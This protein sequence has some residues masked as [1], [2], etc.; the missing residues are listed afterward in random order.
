M[1]DLE[2]SSSIVEERKRNLLKNLKKNNLWISIVILVAILIFGFYIR[3]LNVPLLKDA[4]T[5]GYITADL[6]PF[7]FLRYSRTILETGSLPSVDYM[8]YVPIGYSSI[9]EFSFLSYSIVYLF[10]FLS[11]FNPNMTIELAAN[12]YPPIA[13]VIGLI[14]FFLLVRKLFNDKIALI[15]T[16]FLAVIPTFLYR[17]MAGVADKEPMATIFFFMTFYFY[18][19]GYKSDKPWKHI[20]FGALA[21]VATGILSRVWGGVNFVYMILGLFVIVSLLFFKF[22]KKDF[23]LYSS[24]FIVMLPI[25]ILGKFSLTALLVSFTSGIAFVAFFMGLVYYTVF[26]AK[27][28]KIKETITEK[29][30]KGFLITIISLVLLILFASVFVDP[31]FIIDKPHAL[32]HELVNPLEDRWSKTVAESH[33]SYFSD[34][35]GNYGN[36]VTLFFMAG[37]ILLFWNLVK[38]LKSKIY[39]TVAYTVFIVLFGIHKYSMDAASLNGHSNLA[40]FLLVGSTLIFL[41][42]L[43]YGY[44]RLF[45]SNK[46]EFGKI[47]ESS[48]SYVFVLIWFIITLLAALRAVRL[49][50]IFSPIV[51]ILVAYLLYEGIL[52]ANEKIKNK[53]YK[54]LAIGLILILMINPFIT[55]AKDD[56]SIAKV[57]GPIY[58]GQW[59]Y[60]M[61]WVR[62]NTPKDAVFAHWWDYGYWVQTGGERA[63]VTDG[64]NAIGSWN[65]FMGRN[66]ITGQNDSESLEF[67]YA[68]N[69]SYLL[70][71]SD[72][73][74]KYPAFSSIGSNKDF[75]RYTQISS[76]VIDRTKTQETRNETSY[77]YLGGT[78]IDEDIIIDDTLLP[79]FGAGIGGFLVPISVN[80]DGNVTFTGIPYAFVIYNN[81][82]YNVPINCIYFEKQ[83]YKLDIESPIGGCLRYITKIDGTQGD[84]IGALL[85]MSNKVMKGNF[86]RLYL[87]EQETPAFKLVYN[88]ESLGVP[89]AYYNGR[90][91]GPTKVWKIN[92]PDGYSISDE[93]RTMYLANYFPEGVQ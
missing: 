73:I 45:K 2:N 43:I 19:V 28:I 70:M 53:N 8:R 14:F 47:F 33:E 42:L 5:G 26:E 63:T 24:W 65:Y 76:F 21:G 57:T 90:I 79:R 40:I 25:V 41:G 71:V 17:T 75:D 16:A 55:Y 18:F 9:V 67:L 6:D 11:I 35:L 12:L 10:K 72:E 77:V 81:K 87:F 56:I 3:T 58:N 93:L 32:V 44:Y 52:F 34:I 86:G 29:L 60:A 80:T 83:I 91:I 37:S 50:F 48:K 92:Y 78:A 88:D 82:Q 1:N 4:T 51:A 7:A 36:W 30:P 49:L 22:E 62:E 27:L 68:H 61:Q 64:G 74:G 20:L 89:L 85:Y 31:L 84:R 38:K 23:L 54:I 46:E 39:L 13:F 59:Q 15:A 69:A 66:V